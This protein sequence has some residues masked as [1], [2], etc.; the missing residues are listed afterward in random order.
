M[1]PDLALQSLK[2]GNELYVKAIKDSTDLNTPITLRDVDLGQQPFAIIL[3][4][5]DSRVPAELIFNCGIGELFIIRVAG[6]IASPT[7]IGSIEYACQ[8]LG[9]QLVVVMGHSHCGAVSATIGTLSNSKHELSPNL[10]SIIDQITP[11]VR[12]IVEADQ[13]AD[14]ADDESLLDKAVRANV[15]Y[16]VNNLS[17]QSEVLSTLMAEQKLAVIGAE[18]ALET[19]KVTFHE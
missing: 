16:T 7:Q 19:G 11:A 18:Y 3:S 13:H 14:E 12:P 4:C 1:N 9:A 2:D 17:A 5:S 8:N 6:N 10:E 15:S